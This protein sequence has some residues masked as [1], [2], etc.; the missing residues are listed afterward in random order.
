MPNASWSYNK[1]VGRLIDNFLKY[2]LK[3]LIFTETQYYYMSINAFQ[4]VV[5]L[6]GG[7]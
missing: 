3:C 5:L 7:L 6:Q 2:R 4:S 1:Q